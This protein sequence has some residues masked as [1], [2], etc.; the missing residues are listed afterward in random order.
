MDLRAV[1]LFG[2]I[3][4]TSLA[5]RLLCVSWQDGASAVVERILAQLQATTM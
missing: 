4:R 1:R 2:L 3:A 5:L